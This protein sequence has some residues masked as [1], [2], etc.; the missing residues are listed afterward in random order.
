MACKGT[1]EDGSFAGSLRG[2]V[3]A[4]DGDGSGE[5]PVPL[6][7]ARAV[8]L[9]YGL[10]IVRAGGKVKL[11]SLPPPPSLQGSYIVDRRRLGEQIK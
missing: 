5:C 10:R 11:K 4:R 6:G 3:C 2:A 9:E 1:A 7:R 8:G